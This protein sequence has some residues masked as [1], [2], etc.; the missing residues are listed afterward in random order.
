M[1]TQMNRLHCH[2]LFLAL[3]A[4]AAASP[5]CAADFYAGKTLSLLINY[6]PGGPADTEG[7]LIARHLGKHI[8]GNPTIVIRNMPGAGG[9]VG[10]NWLGTVAP[11]DGST[12]GFLTGVTSKAALA[13]VNFKADMSKYAFVAGVSGI[14]IAFIRTD[15][16]PGLKKPEDIM[17]AKDFWVGGLT[18]DSDK[19]IRMRL[20]LDMLGIPHKY[21][22]GYGNTADARLALQRNELQ[23]YAESSPTYRTT[24]EP[25]LVATG[26]AIP[27]WHDS[28]DLGAG[29]VRSPEA[30]GIEA[31]TY[32]EFLLKQKG[33]FPTGIMWDSFRRLNET[34]TTFLRLYVMAPGTQKEALDAIRAG[35]VKLSLDAEFRE[36]AQRTMKFTPTFFTG[37]KAEI[38]FREKLKSDPAIVAFMRDYIE[39]GKAANGKK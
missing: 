18:V 21:I 20:E 39:K 9:V 3:S 35:I 2:F 23:M 31:P 28:V 38:S 8:A 11:T 6:A 17:K 29:L 10:A 22:T 25:G 36:E 16:P 27:L 33:A 26:Q 19:D 15:V 1:G 32:E 37:D 30:A 24:I 14:S 13:D 34:G 7:R 12:L 4:I 5:S